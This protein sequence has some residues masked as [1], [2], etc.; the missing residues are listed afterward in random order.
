M[1]LAAACA[2]VV[3]VVQQGQW[4]GAAR[5]GDRS[6][7]FIGYTEGLA[8][9]C[10]DRIDECPQLA[11]ENGCIYNA[12]QMRKFCPTTCGVT[13]CVH[14]AKKVRGRGGTPRCTPRHAWLQRPPFHRA[15][16]LLKQ[17][18][19]RGH[20]TTEGTTAY[21]ALMARQYP[22]PARAFTRVHLKPQGESPTARQSS[23]A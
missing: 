11:H 18:I 19:H 21:R 14:G 22:L 12:F 8:G 20:A 17:V 2:V 13:R 16:P 23:A 3:L 1:R 6:D 10:E 7:S 9:A 4:C 5:L 15:L